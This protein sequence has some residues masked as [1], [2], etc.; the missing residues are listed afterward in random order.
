MTDESTG[1]I[2][3]D[4]RVNDALRTLVDEMLSRIRE[5]SA[6]EQ[7]TAD[8]RQ[9]AEQDLERVMAQVRREAQSDRERG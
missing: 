5:M 8:E 2:E 3:T 9:R 4:R 1:S 6:Q 7:W